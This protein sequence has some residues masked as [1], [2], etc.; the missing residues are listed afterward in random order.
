MQPHL[1]RF[2]RPFPLRSPI[3]A[4]LALALIAPACTLKITDFEES[5]SDSASASASASTSTSMTGDSDSTTTG[6]STIS[7]G[8]TSDGTNLSGTTVDVD[9]DTDGTT[10]DDTTTAS[11]TSFGPLP[12]CKAYTQDPETGD[13]E[14]CAEELDCADLNSKEACHDANSYYNLDTFLL[15]HCRW[16]NLLTGLYIE[17][18]GICDGDVTGTCVAA[19][20]I[21]E[22]PACD[23][24][25]RDYGDS[26]E[27]LNLK[28][29]APIAPD[30]GGC[31]VDPE[32]PE[33]PVC[34]CLPEVP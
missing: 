23:G 27:V 10:S 13:A 20:G 21:T 30:W 33:I 4:A 6:G 7:D 32:D 15:A 8:T 18:E 19:T 22:G 5:D 34:N 29:G 17:D 28:C 26:V 3:A 12:A 1:A 9:T 31:H 25:Y 24:Y 14:A 11:D 2:T 16:G